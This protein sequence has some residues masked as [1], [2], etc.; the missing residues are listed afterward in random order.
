MGLKVTPR[1]LP[2]ETLLYHT[3][4]LQNAQPITPLVLAQV[5]RPS[6][7]QAPCSAP[8]RPLAA[9]PKPVLL[10]LEHAA[11]ELPEGRVVKT[12]VPGG[13]SVPVGLG[14]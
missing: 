11:S 8:Q 12:W 4:S 3:A 2:S 1:L 9:F 13:A 5:P 14:A 10:K 7:S 6:Q